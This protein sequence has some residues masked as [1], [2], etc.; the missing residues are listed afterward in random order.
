MKKNTRRFSTK[1]RGS[2]RVSQRFRMVA[3]AGILSVALIGAAILVDFFGNTRKTN[4]NNNVN[5][6][7][8]LAEFRY[9]KQLNFNQKLLPAEGI[10]RDFP[11]MVCLR[12][13]GLRSV[14]NGGKVVSEKG[15]DIRFTGRDG[16]SL[17]DYE[18]EKYDARTGEL[19]AWV[20][21]DSLRKNASPHI[22][23]YFGNEY[24]ADE[25]SQNTWNR[26]YK[27][28]WHLKGLLSS[29]TPFA[30]Q[31]ANAGR[32]IQAKENYP[33]SERNSSRY[34]CLN[35]SEDINIKNQLTVSAWVFVSENRDQV[36]ITNQSHR[37]GGYRLGLSRQNKLEFEICN[38]KRETASIKGKADGV[39]LE[40]NTWYHVAAVYSDNGDS[41]TTY[42]NGM[43]DRSIK[44]GVS[45][46]E[47]P[48]PLH[49]GQDPENKIYR[50]NGYLDE[51]HVSDVCLTADWI[52][53]EYQNQSQPGIFLNPGITEKIQQQISMSLL[54][55]DAMQHGKT[56]DLNWL[57]A[58]ET[59]NESFT[60]ERSADG[61]TFNEIGNRP[62]AGNSNEVLRY[63]FKD[64][65][66]L[67]GINYYRIKLRASDGNEEYSMVTPA[68]F[69][70]EKDRTIKIASAG[71]NPFNKELA[72]DYQVPETGKAR[73]RLTDM[74][75]EIL[76]DK[77]VY[78]NKSEM[79]HLL[80]RDIQ[81][82]GDG[83]IFLNVAQN[84]M[85]K[86]VKL[87]RRM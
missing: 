45:M 29:K 52:L 82:H 24:A 83:V 31:L 9:R 39:S 8:T 69:E 25:N 87:L 53:A 59:E 37:R 73:V 30:N 2:V 46:S 57:T 3:A 68:R 11:L 40:N 84:E 54:S 15:F 58:S 20:R 49:F 85:S 70:S 16:I 79:H 65:A 5:G 22:F 6:Q 1:V 10:L 33:V 34:T 4:A 51:I 38:D 44:T 28:V 36:I 55:L 12:D 63:R 19:L 21:I 61:V 60:I 80:I 64:Q 76:M 75:G 13:S 47:S 50:F 56:I 74:K 17:L 86:T 78:C 14:S 41:M 62:G 7:Q 71:P 27:G 48:D 35:T 43:R 32:V 67:A 72:I 81:N 26:T 66:P 18:I 42:I 77:E 23:M